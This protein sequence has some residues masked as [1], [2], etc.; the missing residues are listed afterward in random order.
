MRAFITVAEAI[1]EFRAG[2]PVIIVDDEDRENEGDLAVAAEFATPEIV[3]F[4]ATQGRGLVCMPMLGQRLDELQIPLMVLR[5]APKQASAFTV[6]VDARHRTT[7]GISAAD[8]AATVQ[9]LLDPS[10]RP[11]DL[12]RPGHLFPLRYAEGGVL[13]RAGHTEASVD[14]A[15][16]AGLYPAAVICETMNPDG[17]MARL[18]NLEQFAAQHGIKIISIAQLVEYRRRTE[19]L[20]RRVAETV[21]PNTH[22]AWRAIAYESLATRDTHLVLS[23]GDLSAPEPPLVRMHSECLTGDIFGSTNCACVQLLHASM[24]LI[25][26]EGR[27]VVVYLRMHQGRGIGLV[28]YPRFSWRDVTCE[29]ELGFHLGFPSDPRDYGIGAQIL[30]DLGLRHLRLLTN[31]PQ[32]RAGL[33]GFGLE[34]VEAVPVPPLA[35]VLQHEQAAPA[36]AETAGVRD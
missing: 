10:T 34:I 6:S 35:A 28:S 13:R 20:V 24:A 7:T 9:A 8:R 5:N 33:Q 19:K 22:G 1:E 17:T 12:I 36:L 32:K 18:P 25:A 3:N 23:M 31:N 27:G 15:R 14:L 26:R 4:M 21:L 2:R 16:L 29:P 11:D 30:E